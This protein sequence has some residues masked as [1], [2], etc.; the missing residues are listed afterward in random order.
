M[1]HVFFPCVNCAIHLDTILPSVADLWLRLCE[2]RSYNEPYILYYHECTCTTNCDWV[3]QYHLELL[4]KEG[5]IVSHEF[6]PQA[7]IIRLLGFEEDDDAI[8]CA[9]H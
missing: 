1:A 4:E 6:E 2:D 5:Y 7:F 8:C 3:F 9:R